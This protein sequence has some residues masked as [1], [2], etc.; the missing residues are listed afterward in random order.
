M[1]VLILF[2]TNEGHTHKIARFLSDRLSGQG[3]EV[4]MADA[5]DLPV[6]LSPACHDLVIVA[7]RVHAGASPRAVLG[8]VRRRREALQRMPTAFISVSMAAARHRPGDAEREAQYVDQFI[9]ETGWMP[10]H[11]YHAAGA[12]LYTKHNALTRWIL[13]LVDRHRDDTSCDHEFT[14]WEKLA[15]FADEVADAANQLAQEGGG[16]GECA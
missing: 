1:R 10:R 13:G 5:R 2:G 8:F 3:H 14:D 9:A 16:D 4:T 15:A 11:I 7:A 12:R 6:D